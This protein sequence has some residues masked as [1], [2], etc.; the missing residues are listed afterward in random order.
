MKPKSTEQQGANRAVAE[1]KTVG[2]NKNV[3]A[4]SANAQ[5]TGKA[6]G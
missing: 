6:V 3:N 1:S 4:N 5:Q 2:I